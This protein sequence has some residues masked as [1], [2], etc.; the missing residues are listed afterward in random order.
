M[1]IDSHCHLDLPEF[2]PDRKEVIRRA[3]D[4]GLSALI[5]IGIG[6]VSSKKAVEIAESRENPGPVYAT[7]GVHPHDA[8]MVT[9]KVLDELKILSR[10]ERVV[11]LGETGLDFY[12]NLSPRDRQ[13]KA[14]TEFLDLSGELKLPI[15]IHDR[16]AHAEVLDILV[17]RKGSYV[18]GVIH[19]FSGDWNYAKTCM[20][21]GF[22]ISIPGVVTFPKATKLHDVVRRLPSDGILFETDA[23]FLAPN[24]HRGRR[25][26]P[27]YVKYVAKEVAKLRGEKEGEL[28]EQVGKNTCDVFK[29]NIA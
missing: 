9:Q 14:F 24:P 8:K 7:V 10:S 18:P 1:L 20:N 27:A 3:F 19:C 29:I 16:D 22:S 5:T 21:L 6:L 13:V 15:I 23:P 2:N 11:G 28:V 25:N 17:T 26:E 12:R 4:G